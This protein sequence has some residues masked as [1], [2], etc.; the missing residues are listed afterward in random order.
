MAAKKV[1]KKKTRRKKRRETVYVH[2]SLEAY[3]RLENAAIRFAER[4][5]VVMP[6]EGTYEFWRK[7]LVNAAVNY[8]KKCGN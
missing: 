4:V 6:N 3:F 2:K 8:S 5:K 1:A 7:E